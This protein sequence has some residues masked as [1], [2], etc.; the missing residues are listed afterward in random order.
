MPIIYPLSIPILRKNVNDSDGA[1]QNIIGK[2]NFK[3]IYI[4]ED[5][6]MAITGVSNYN[7]VY[8]NIYAS[9]RKEA[10]KKEKRNCG[11][12]EKH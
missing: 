1:V 12:A 3:N 7:S 10:A 2:R 4:K 5:K 11:C 9:S 8:E 6:I